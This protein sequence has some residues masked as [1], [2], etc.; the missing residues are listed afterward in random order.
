MGRN[1]QRTQVKICGI[2]TQEDVAIL[3]QY[4]PDY[5]GFVFFEKSKRFVTIEQ[6]KDLTAG[7]DPE[8]KRVAVCVDP[9]AELAMNLQ[10]AGFDIVQVHGKI[11][12]DLPDDFKIPLWQAIHMTGE[13]F[14]M[15]APGRHVPE[16]YLADSS[17]Y[18]SGKTFDWAGCKDWIDAFLSR[19]RAE[20]GQKIR[21][22]LAGGL[23]PDNVRQGIDMLAPDIVDVSSGVEYADK[24]GKDP[25]K[26][27]TFIENAR[28]LA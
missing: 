10:E 5:A 1:T 17:T 28:G 4:R 23:H 25:V 3:N 16:T 21:F 22:A 26:V 15:P 11:P 9:A 14:D 7:L 12:E 2:T 8:I 6:A 18:G 13:A 19:M 20:T 27:K 24:K